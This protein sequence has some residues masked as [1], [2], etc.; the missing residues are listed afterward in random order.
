MIKIIS[1]NSFPLK[2]KKLIFGVAR[3]FTEK[4]NL[5]EKLSKLA[6]T[7]PL[8]GIN[9]RRNFF[10]L[11]KKEF[12]R[13]KRYSSKISLLML[14]IDNFKAIN[15]TYGHLAGDIVLK[16][17]VKKIKEIL[18]ESD[19]PC[20]FGGEEFAILLIESGKNESFNVAERI[21]HDIAMSNI[22]WQNQI[23]KFTVSIGL[24]LIKKSDENLDDIIHRADKALYRAKGKGKNRIEIEN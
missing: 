23:V 11:A 20:R 4:K 22:K 24:T 9:N 8:T 5:E 18:R 14:D 10:N 3:D 1:W 15:D 13:F 6:V 7:D 12:S 21:R 17:L 19:I 2:S 16:E